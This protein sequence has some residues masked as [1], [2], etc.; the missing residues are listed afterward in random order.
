MLNKVITLI[1]NV[2]LRP[3]NISTARAIYVFVN[4]ILWLTNMLGE[5]TEAPKLESLPK[6]MGKGFCKYE[7]SRDKCLMGEQVETRSV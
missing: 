4:V 7:Y 2:F 3:S 1:N 5:S 6:I